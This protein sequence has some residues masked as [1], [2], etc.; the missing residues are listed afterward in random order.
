MGSIDKSQLKV[1][2]QTI[3]DALLMSLEG[4]FKE[5]MVVNRSSQ[6][7]SGRNFRNISDIHSARCSLTGIHSA[8]EN[9]YTEHVFICSCDTPFMNRKLVRVLL[10]K[11]QPEDDVLIPVH[12]NNMLEPLCA[13]YSKRCLPFITANLDSNIFQ[14]IKFFPEVRVA[15]I[16][17][18]EL[19]EADP[20]LESFINVNTPEELKAACAKAEERLPRVYSK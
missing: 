18:L 19:Q 16:P 6:K 3:L 14:I 17:T 13:V 10:N 2:G 1:G 11:L 20:K 4:L 5:I 9:S 7:N 15:K 12:E 8:L